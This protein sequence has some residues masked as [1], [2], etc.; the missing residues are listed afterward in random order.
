MRKM[1]APPKRLHT[2]LT[3]ALDDLSAI[4]RDKR[5]QVNMFYWHRPIRH[6]DEK[7][8]CQVCLGGA[9]M[10]RRVGLN[11][12]CE[13]TPSSPQIPTAW[14]DGLCA[15]DSLRSGGVE[16]AV[17]DYYWEGKKEC[18]VDDIAVPPYEDDRRGFKFTLRRLARRLREANL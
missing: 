6:L 3:M 11:L 8:M 7:R 12:D 18:R 15:L 5:Y 16:S 14:R 13:A 4:E 17:N 9:V 2:L 1:A 10:A